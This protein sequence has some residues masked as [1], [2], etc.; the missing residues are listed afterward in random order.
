MQELNQ[1]FA[2]THYD[3]GF[4]YGYIDAP[5]SNIEDHNKATAIT[6]HDAETY[7]IVGI[8]YNKKGEYDLAIA[9]FSRA[10]EM[11]SEHISAYNDRGVAYD[12]KR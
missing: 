4:V 5:N 12:R 10:I 9:N 1:E 7:N 2:T 11:N 8:A 6:P 3:S